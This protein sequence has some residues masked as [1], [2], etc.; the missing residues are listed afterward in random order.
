MHKVK[1]IFYVFMKLDTALTENKDFSLTI[2]DILLILLN[3]KNINS[4]NLKVS[5]MT[6]VIFYKH[7]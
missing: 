7:D 3:S 2:M 1:L 4:S 6:Y 5:S